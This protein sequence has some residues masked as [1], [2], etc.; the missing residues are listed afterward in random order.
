MKNAL[1]KT[2]AGFRKGIFSILLVVKNVLDSLDV[3]VPVELGEVGRQL[4]VFR[5]GADAVLAVAAAGDAA[6]L[7][8]CLQAFRL[9]VL[10]K[11]VDVEEIRLDD[12]GRADEVG[13]RADVRASF[14][15]AAAG[16]A[17]GNL[18]GR[19]CRIRV[20]AR[21]FVYFPRAVHVDPALYFLQAVKHHRAVDQKVADD[22]ESARRSEVDR[23]LQLVNEGAARLL[24]LS[25][26][27][28]HA[29][30]AN[31]FEAVAFPNH[32]GNTLA[33]T[34][35]GIL[36][37]FHQRRDHVQ[38]GAVGDVKLLGVGFRV[39]AVLPLDDKGDCLLFCHFR[40]SFTSSRRYA[41]AA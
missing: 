15:A 5:A 27:D 37:D 32:R 21:R 25:V 23:L 34:G 38:R 18:V 3:H 28:H 35:D 26:D 9:V 14:H 30:A 2:F 6:F 4:D 19:G 41:P 11:R 7:H 16:H 24:R 12:R 10:A 22:R 36:L 40:P 33:V 20:L 29:R 13:L 8:Q 1:L 17:M 39:G 31:F